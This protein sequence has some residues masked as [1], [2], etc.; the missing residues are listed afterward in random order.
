M[1]DHYSKTALITGGTRGIGLAIAHRLADDGYA[2]A[3]SYRHLANHAEQAADSLRA[4]GATVRCYR[5]DA[6]DPDAARALINRV[7]ADFGQIDV[8]INNAGITDDA[9]F[10]TMEPE[11]IA[12]VLQTNLIGAIHVT[13]A[14]LPHLLAG[15]APVI[16]NVASLGGINGKEG[17][18]AYSA[19]K[20]GLIGFTRWLGRR[21]SERGLRVNAVAPGFV[22]TDMVSVLHP[23][24]YA[25]VLAGSAL[26]RM[27]HTTEI[28][29]AVGFLLRPGY[30]QSTTLRLDGGFLR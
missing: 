9:A 29:E 3:L 20:G 12:A 18:V 19:S 28:A 10:F 6:A 7:A 21:Y 15:S 30:I 1:S 11:R 23:D 26:G 27:G 8:L 4:Q 13:G 24:A 5:S 22:D 25:P 16:V 14:A 17:Q 2:L